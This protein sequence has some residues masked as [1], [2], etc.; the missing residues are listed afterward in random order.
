MQSKPEREVLF[1][2]EAK[3]FRVDTFRGTGPGGQHRNK[4]ES[5]VRIT[6]IESGMAASACESRSQATNKRVAFRRL[7]S[8]LI[9]HYVPARQKERNASGD[10]VVR[11]YHAVDNRVK[12]AASGLVQPWSTVMEDGTMMIDARRGALD[13][14]NHPRES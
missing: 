11:T 7:A 8:K 14:T 13:V 6:H 3:D 10:V 4:T 2:A 1:H 9:A 12:D 5:C